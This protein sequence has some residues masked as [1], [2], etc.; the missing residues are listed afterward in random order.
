[1]LHSLD[2]ESGSIHEVL[3]LSPDAVFIGVVS[4]DNRWLYFNRVT[5]EA[6]IW[7]LTL[8]EERQ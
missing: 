6:D 3:N 2:I 7:M 1:V 8:N 5:V 4:P